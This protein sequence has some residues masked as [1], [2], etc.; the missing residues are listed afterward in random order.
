MTHNRVDLQSELNKFKTMF[1]ELLPRNPAL[2]CKAPIY[3]AIQAKLYR[4]G[5][6]DVSPFDILCEVWLLGVQ[7]VERGKPIKKIDAWVYTVA[8]RVIAGKIPKKGQKKQ[9]FVE[10]DSVMDERV[11]SVN[12]PEKIYGECDDASNPQYQK[13]RQAL[14][15]LNDQERDI[16]E[17]TVLD[18]WSYAE[19]S[20]RMSQDGKP[21]VEPTAL[22]QQKSR[23]MKKLKK[24]YHRSG[25]L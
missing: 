3:L 13:V 11:A 15:Q 23:A 25:E 7:S 10:Y 1:D 22:R 21:V 17:A 9:R 8:L 5:L 4:S 6:Y 18:G 20:A 14:Q 2:L 12:T 16:L 19:I 24:F